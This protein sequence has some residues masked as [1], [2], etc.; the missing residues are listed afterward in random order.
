MASSLTPIS[1][2]DQA[3]AAANTP[4]ES[5]SLE[6][7]AA[8]DKAFHKEQ[9]DF[10]KAAEDCQN[11]IKARRHTTRL[12][13]PHIKHGGDRTQ[14]N[15]DVTLLVDYGFTRM[16]WQR[17]R[18][19]LDVPGDEL[20]KYFDDCV[21]KGC[22]PTPSGLIGY[23]NNPHVE[24]NSGEN[25]WYTPPEYIAAARLVMGE[26]DL[27]PASTEIANKI[28]G[29]S[30]FYSEADDGLAQEWSGRVW[31]NPPYASE[32]V[33]QFCEK[34]A[35][36]FEGKAIPQA[37]ALVNNATETAWFGRLAQTAS[38]VVFPR[39][40]IKFLDPQ[41]RP[42]APLQGQAVIYLGDDPREFLKHFAG[43]G[44]G[45]RL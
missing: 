7:K 39:G 32:L 35:A 28:V 40:R 13:E 10:E 37:I 41:G 34:L 24:H 15:D 1:K 36:T 30:I 2:F 19:E 16:Q 42:G 4:R 5:F 31:M 29:A 9:R 6:A 45:A 20:D 14:S 26:I 38:A 33:G 8:S 25:E 22:L 21:M 12:I 23:M 44:W 18:R 17:R 3:L 43:F 11:Y 27:D